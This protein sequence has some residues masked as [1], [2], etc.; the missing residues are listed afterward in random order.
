MLISLWITLTR[1]PFDDYYI[2]TVKG[3]RRTMCLYYS[4]G[5]WTDDN[6]QEYEVVAWMPMPEAYGVNNK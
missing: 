3:A 5:K 4:D 1:P 6:N 2:V